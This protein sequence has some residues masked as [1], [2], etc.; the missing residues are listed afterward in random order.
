[1]DPLTHVMAG[2]LVSHACAGLSP[3]PGMT[4]AAITAAIVPDLDFYSRKLPGATFLRVHHGV[5]HS[6]LSVPIQAAISCIPAWLIHAI[7]QFHLPAIPFISLFLICSLSV[8]SHLVIDWIMHNNGLPL[9]WPFQH[10]RFALPLILG[11]NPR[12]VSKDCGEQRF[13]TCFG[14]QSRASLW[15][16]IAWI[17][18]IF[19]TAGFLVPQ[20]RTA[21]GLI[22]L[23][24]ILAYLSLSFY[25]RQKARDVAVRF[26]PCYRHAPAYPSRARPD[27]WLFVASDDPDSVSAILIDSLSAAVLRTWRFTPPLL[28]PFVLDHTQR[29]ISDLKKSIRHMYPEV[30]CRDA[31]T[32]VKFR[33]LSFLYAEPLEIGS[34]KVVLDENGT[35]ISEVYQEVW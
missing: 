3:E 35:V 30:T 20:W 12:T 18:T 16:P 27:R 7:P 10:R 1:M 2:A 29:I 14:C 28:S 33:D 11:V 34:V 31:L 4:I 32:F 21:M 17:I 23:L 24:P 6:F 5:T 13:L 19:G 8:L 15:N 25:L 26:D 9:L 22:P